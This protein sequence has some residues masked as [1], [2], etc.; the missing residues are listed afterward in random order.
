M[1]ANGG[2]LQQES[3]PASVPMLPGG[4]GAPVP[5][6]PNRISSAEKVSVTISNTKL[7]SCSLLVPLQLVPVWPL[8][9]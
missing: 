4:P 1:Y 3:I 5:G 2:F 7:M 9:P 6:E 8:G